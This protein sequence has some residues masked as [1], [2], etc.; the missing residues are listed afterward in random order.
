MSIE[1][2]YRAVYEFT[3]GHPAIVEALD[4][5]M[6]EAMR[7]KDLRRSMNQMANALRPWLEKD[8]GG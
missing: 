2:N 4:R 7:A 1:S 8:D 3:S 6:K 5:L